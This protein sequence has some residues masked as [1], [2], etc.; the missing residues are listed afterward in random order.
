MSTKNGP[1]LVAFEGGPLEISG[2]VSVVDAEGTP[3][4]S[5][6]AGA[7]IYLCRCGE[8]T[9]KPFCD[10]SH[11]ACE[12]SAM[13]AFPEDKLKEPAPDAQPRV[14]VRVLRDGPLVCDGAFRVAVAGDASRPTSRITVCRCGQSKAAPVCDG[15]HKAA[16]FRAG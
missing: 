5:E 3:I 4:R 2:P 1:R 9:D 11:Q 14:H 13:G 12:Y 7:S 15:S 16:G 8:S 6:P 10:G